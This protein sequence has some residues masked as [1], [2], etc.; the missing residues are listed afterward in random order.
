MFKNVKNKVEPARFY[1]IFLQ[2]L[3]FEP[4]LH[5]TND[6][7]VS[8]FMKIS[9]AELVIEKAGFDELFL[10][11]SSTICAH[12]EL[13]NQKLKRSKQPWRWKSLRCF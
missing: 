8:P 3:Y 12:R 13:N 6:F 11:L 7:L 5:P 4:Q 9:Y 1:L 10:I 2:K